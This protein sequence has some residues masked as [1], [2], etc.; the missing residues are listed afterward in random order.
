MRVAIFTDTYLP[1]VNGVTHTLGLLK[2]ALQ[3]NGHHCMILAPEYTRAKH[4]DDLSVWRFKSIP[5]PLYSECRLSIPVYGPLASKVDRFK[6]DI[7]HIVTPLGIGHAGA[8][9]AKERNLPAVAS[10]HTNFDVYLKYYNMQHFEK[11]LW[12]FFKIFH[13]Q[14]ITNFCPSQDT[15]NSLANH[16]IENL[17]IWSRG[18]DTQT[19]SPLKRS[20][21]FYDQFRRRSH[22]KKIKCLYAGRIALEKDL[23]ILFESIQLVNQTH[24]QQVEFFIVGDGPERL[25]LQESAPDNVYFTGFLSGNQ[26]TAAY[27]SADL[28]TFASSTETLGNVVL[29]AM[30]SA[31]PVIAVSAGGILDNVVSD[32]NGILCPPR[33]AQSFSQA[34]VGLVDD[35]AKRQQLAKQA[36]DS[37][38]T[39]TWDYVFK[40]LFA[41]YQRAIDTCDVTALA[42]LVV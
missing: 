8:R 35:P 41:D 15:L 24:Q 25:R 10:F 22:D 33:D 6:P 12:A 5:F 2:D 11:Y 9:Y 38:Q 7:I 34:I 42:P 26:L 27:A 36:L 23:D 40:Q 1:E 39:K 21:Y 4:K 37:V 28:F 18:I 13:N 14:F 30:A 20:A 3:K 17:A 32:Y 19:F 29:E 31:L 16:G